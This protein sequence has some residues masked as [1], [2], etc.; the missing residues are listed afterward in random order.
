MYLCRGN[1]EQVQPNCALLPTARRVWRY[2]QQVVKRVENTTAKLA[3]VRALSLYVGYSLIG[4]LSIYYALVYLRASKKYTTQPEETSS[5]I[6][7]RIH[8]QHTIKI[9]LID[10][11]MMNIKLKSA[12][13]MQ[14][15]LVDNNA[16]LS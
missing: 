3:L 4:W 14:K 16:K 11:N 8:F 9:I 5:N 2:L 12:A 7:N 10:L 15:K 6:R 13:S 1:V